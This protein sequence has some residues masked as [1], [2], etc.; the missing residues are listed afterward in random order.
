MVRKLVGLLFLAAGIGVFIGAI[1][2]QIAWLGICFGTVIIGILLL[3]L[4]PTILLFP[5][6]I[7]FVTGIAIWGAGMAMV[8]SDGSSRSDTL[9]KFNS[10]EPGE[11]DIRIAEFINP[12][13]KE[14]QA[15]GYS[16][17][18]DLVVIAYLM[19]VACTVTKKRLSL[20]DL[21]PTCHGIF[22]SRPMDVDNAF[23]GAITNHA[24]YQEIYKGVKGYVRDELRNGSG[25][26]LVKYAQRMTAEAQSV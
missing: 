22:P 24:K 26:F 25:D 23:H 7:G 10:L 16:R 19:A 3:F 15:M 21:K 2:A 8:T 17:N 1:A 14:I 18:I 11:V 9:R 5:V 20:A 13:I 4:A 6:N 12:Q